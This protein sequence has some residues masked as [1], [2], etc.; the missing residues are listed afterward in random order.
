MLEL[1]VLS[2]CLSEPE[3]CKPAMRAVYVQKP[4]YRAAVKETKDLAVRYA[5]QWVLYAAPAA[6]IATR[7]GTAQLKIT[8]NL[9]LQISENERIL[10]FS[11]TF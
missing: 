6:A 7:T 4:Y 3:A 8:R 1:F 5:G 10:N 9:N 11:Y 2:L